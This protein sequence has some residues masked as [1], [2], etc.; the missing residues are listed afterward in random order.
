MAFSELPA[1][2]ANVQYKLTLP[3]ASVLNVSDGEPVQLAAAVTG[4][5]AVSA[6]LN[7][8]INV[9][10]AL[11]PGSQL[12]AGVVASTGTYV[13]RAIPGGTGVTAKVVFE[14][15]V[16]SGA[17]VTV[18]YKGPDFGDTWI[19]VPQTAS[20]AVDDGF[21]EFT[22]VLGSI[23]ETSV[24]IRLTLA[25]TTAARPRVRDLRCFVL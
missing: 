3:D 13:S 5:I 16:P 4:D 25:G 21:F 11:H 20:V 18:H 12:V 2:M 22:H 6:V 15:F 8:T 10:P 23:T 7:G 19:S 1:G 9:S 24:Q 14:A 17:T